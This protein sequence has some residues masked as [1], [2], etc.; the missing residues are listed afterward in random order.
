[1]CASWCAFQIVDCVICTVK[2]SG[3]A[4]VLLGT[5]VGSM[6]C[7][8]CEQHVSCLSHIL[9]GTESACD[10]IDDKLRMAVHPGDEV[11]A[12]SI[13]IALNGVNPGHASAI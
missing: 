9:F 12:V 13:L 1:M 4:G 2:V 5:Y 6:L 10:H 7:H 11:V 8:A 3:D